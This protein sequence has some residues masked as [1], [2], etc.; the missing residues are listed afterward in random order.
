MLV[1]RIS[2]RN[3][4]KLPPGNTANAL[5]ANIYLVAINIQNTTFN[6]GT[7]TK[8]YVTG[9]EI[10]KKAMHHLRHSQYAYL[11]FLHM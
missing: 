1:G 8:C 4:L 5:L 3:A 2:L 10:S 6:R 7:H 9:L 11:V